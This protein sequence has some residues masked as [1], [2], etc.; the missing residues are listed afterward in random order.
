MQKVGVKMFGET[1][2]SIRESKNMTLKEAAGD[3]VSI[4]QLSRFENE[5]SI[6]PVDRF[7]EVLNNL[8]TTTEEFNYIRGQEEMREVEKIFDR[9]EDYN[10]NDKADKMRNLRA[11]LQEGRPAPYRWNQFLIYFIDSLLDL[12]EGTDHKAKAPVLDYLMQVEDWGEMELRLYAIFGFVLDIETTHFLMRTALKK[13]KQYLELPATAKLLY[14]ILTNNFST[15]LA[16]GN[17][18]YAEET[19]RLFEENYAKNTKFLSP[20]IDFMFNKGLLAF[21]KKDPEK[22]SKFCEDAITICR[23]FHQY[24]Q[25]KVLSERYK[26]WKTNYDNPDFRELTIQV[27]FFDRKSD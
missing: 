13:S 18:E 15:F 5:K 12:H 17:I 26:N 21:K 22:G 6:I 7:Y 19:I 4:S 25:E 24:E 14:V 23:M 16:S 27:G 20:H 11:E 9:I 10:N 1:I 8:N 3:A 2:K